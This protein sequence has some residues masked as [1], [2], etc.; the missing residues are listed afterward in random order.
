[1]VHHKVEDGSLA[2]GQRDKL[3]VG[4]SQWKKGD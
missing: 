2:T 1:M 3:E 4:S